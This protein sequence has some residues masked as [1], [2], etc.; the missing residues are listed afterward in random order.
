M[1][2]VTPMP[3]EAHGDDDEVNA[4]EQLLRLLGLF[5]PCPGASRLR[6]L[7]PFRSFTLTSLL[8]LLCIDVS[9]TMRTQGCR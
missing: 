2:F 6:S 9:Y 8:L 5:L 3:D 7:S 1:S 4:F